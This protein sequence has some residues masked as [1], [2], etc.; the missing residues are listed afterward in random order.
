M[1]ING[2]SCSLEDCGLIQ[3]ELVEPL[4]LKSAVSLTTLHI[5]YIKY[6]PL[7][8]SCKWRRLCNEHMGNSTLRLTK[9]PK[10][11]AN[12]ENAYLLYV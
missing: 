12:H 4:L 5:N 7:N 6:Q 11:A 1:S 9:H 8:T 3:A 2:K 10:S